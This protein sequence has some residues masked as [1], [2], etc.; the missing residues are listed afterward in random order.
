MS[1]TFCTKETRY[2]AENQKLIEGLR[3]QATKK[4][5]TK[6]ASW[7]FREAADNLEQLARAVDVLNLRTGNE[8]I[9]V[10]TLPPPLG[11]ICIEKANPHLPFIMQ[12]YHT[13]NGKIVDF[14]HLK[15]LYGDIEKRF[16]HLAF[17]KDLLTT[18]EK[19]ELD[20][21]LSLFDYHCITYWMPMPDPEPILKDKEKRENSRRILKCQK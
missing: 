18:K 7:L 10:E 11:A 14:D 2:Q 9:S 5:V 6:Q 3:E 13:Y 8:W 1:M 12:T 4:G 15:H 16:W 21:Y 19:K 17:S 20:F